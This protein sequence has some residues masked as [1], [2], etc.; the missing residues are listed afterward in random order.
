M[1]LLE[2]FGHFEM[3]QGADAQPVELLRSPDEFVF[4]AFDTRSRRLVEL[5]VL[6]GGERLRATEKR[7]AFER[8]QQA[9]G[10]SHRSFMRVLDYGEDSDVVYYSSNLDDG[11]P[12]DA[13]IARRGALSPPT[14]FSLLMQLLD[15]LLH[16]QE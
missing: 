15:D 8:M 16:L 3:A 2:R 14:A 12:L 6:K 9:S 5:H 10:I 7:S 4:L 1:G 13:Y 11:E